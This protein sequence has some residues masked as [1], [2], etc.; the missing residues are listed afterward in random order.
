MPSRR[1]RRSACSSTRM[2]ASTPGWPASARTSS[3]PAP[4]P[5]VTPIWPTSSDG[6]RRWPAISSGRHGGAASARV[7]TALDLMATVLRG[8]SADRLLRR[9]GGFGQ[10]DD[11][12]LRHWLRR[13]GAADVTVE[14]G[15]VRAMYDLVF[16]YRDGDRS[17]PAFP[18]GLGVFLAI[19][20]FLD[21]KG[22][23]FWKMTAGMGD[24]VFAPLHQALTRR[25][26]RHPVLPPGR[27]AAPLRTM[28]AGS[29]RCRWSSRFRPRW[30]RPT[31]PCDRSAGSPASLIA[32]RSTGRPSIRG[33]RPSTDPVR[34]RRCDR[35]SPWGRLRRRGARHP[36]RSARHGRRG[37][38]ATRWALAG[39]DRAREHRSHLVGPGLAPPRRGDPRV[40]APRR[41]H[42]R[43]RRQLRHVRLD[44]S[45]D[46]GGGLAGGR[47]ARLPGLPVRGAR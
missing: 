11:E 46:R 4:P 9:P 21:F 44:E 38:R 2:E 26:R 47:R 27:R 42:R 31:S 15:L 5:A 36:R 39:D 6:Q 43:S 45:P 1:R 29:R 24:T 8:L 30:R 35:A 12:D 33:R 22:A 23:L 17:Q 19:R 28:V 32:R 16:A 34:R 3:F 41:H 25:G 40:A 7:S 20:M 18:A 37:H 10:V 13:H 14:G